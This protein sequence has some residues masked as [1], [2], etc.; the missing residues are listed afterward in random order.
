MRNK[1]LI[2]KNRSFTLIE[3]LIVIAI[4]GILLSLLLP[5]LFKARKKAQ[6]A[7][8]LSNQKQIGTAM[9]AYTVNNDAF[10]PVY[11]DKYV[12]DI[13]WDDQLSDYDG[14]SLSDEQKRES[15]LK[16]ND[17]PDMD[18]SIY[19]CPGNVMER[20]NQYPRSYSINDSYS[21]DLDHINAIRGVAGFINQTANKGEADEYKFSIPWA[22]NLSRVYDPSN[23]IVLF[24]NQ[25]YGNE[26]GHCSGGSGYF[27]A[28]AVAGNWAPINLPK[29]AKDPET[30]GGYYVHE[31]GA[32]VN[33]ANFVNPNRP[34]RHSVLFGDGRAQFTSA[35]GSFNDPTIFYNG[36]SCSWGDLKETGW[37]ALNGR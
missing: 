25:S 24:D 31:T 37:N 1:T 2:H 16:I 14:R 3:L 33:S 12:D 19:E 32:H 18:S 20:V 30:V 29:H 35:P 15:V 34:Y 5:S 21:K 8:C 23:F 22:S 28:K 6:L 27:N 17:Y 36:N 4:I 13:S 26:L 9:M 11:G 7:V 10:Y